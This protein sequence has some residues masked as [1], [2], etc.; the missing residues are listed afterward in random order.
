MPRTVRLL[1]GTELDVRPVEPSDKDLLSRGLE[2]LGPQSRYL[3]FLVPTPALSERQLRYL[4]E[5]DHHDHEALVALDRPTGEGV[6][7][8]RFVRLPDDVQ[9]A[10]FAVAVAD[11]WHG[12]GVATALLALLAD[13]AREEG[14][15]RFWAL[16]LSDN[17]EMLDLL[18]R[19]GPVEVVGRGAGTLEVEVELPAE[20]V[21]RSLRE[22]LRAAARGVIKAALRR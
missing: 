8:A 20:G 14:V 5:V 1:D 18:E 17:Q 13:R 7:V 19:L 16:L 22:L 4:T 9:A 12:R 11:D 3:R 10:E 2:R 15:E 21:D 6:G